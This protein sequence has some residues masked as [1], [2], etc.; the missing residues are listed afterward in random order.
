[1]EQIYNI[2]AIDKTEYDIINF[3]LHAHDYVTA[4]EIAAGCELSLRTVRS[5]MNTVRRRIESYGCSLRAVRSKGYMIP[6]SHSRFLLKETFSRIGPRTILCDGS[7]TD[8]IIS[9]LMENDDH[10]ITMSS[11]ADTLYVSRSTINHDLLEVNEKLNSYQLSVE[12]RAR[13]G[14]RLKGSEQ[15]RRKL[16]VQRSSVS[17]HDNGEINMFLD[18]F[19]NQKNRQEYSV[20]SAIRRCGIHM[21]D[22]SLTE[23]LLYILIA[24]ARMAHGRFIA[25]ETEEVSS[26]PAVLYEN[27]AGI[28]HMLASWGGYAVQ[29]SEISGLAAVIAARQPLHPSGDADTDMAGRIEKRA[30]SLIYEQYRFQLDPY[31]QRSFLLPALSYTLAM[32]K[33]P[34]P[35]HKVSFKS[36]QRDF[37]FPYRLAEATGQAFQEE[38]GLFFNHNNYLYFTAMYRNEIMRL[39]HPPRCALLVCGYGRLASENVRFLVE[40]GISFLKITDT[41]MYSEI[42]EKN[43]SA[44]DLIIS[45]IPISRPMPIPIVNITP[46]VT[47]DDL[48]AIRDKASWVRPGEFIPQIYLPADLFR[49]YTEETALSAAETETA[50]AVEDILEVENPQTILQDG[51]DHAEVLP[52]GIALCSCQE[53]HCRIPMIFGFAASHPFMI[54]GQLAYLVIFIANG[55]YEAKVAAYFVSRFRSLSFADVRRYALTNPDYPHLL[56]L[57]SSVEDSSLPSVTADERFL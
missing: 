32:L 55:T 11:L 37:P 21:S 48:D 18:L 54:Q 4:E 45:T 9:L 14:L 42:D 26:L 49:S 6:D 17:L 15:N 1:M 23:V 12:A 8:A 51:I 52:N 25:G 36:I 2:T 27:S 13:C 30:V 43:L 7:R 29:D 56:D 38:S 22:L 10:F 34:E 47:S 28:I 44:Y 53:L 16:L 3:L 31:F 19:L 33:R 50:M 5:H 41:C 57:I 35:L 40:H 39:H 24:N 46:F 20:L